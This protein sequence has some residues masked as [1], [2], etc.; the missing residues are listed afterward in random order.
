MHDLAMIQLRD[1]LRDKLNAMTQRFAEQGGRITAL[2]HVEC[3]PYKPLAYNTSI[4]RR[5]HARR[6]FL[7]LEQKIAEHGKALA[8]MGLTPD[9]AARKLRERWRSTPRITSL[10]AEQIAA[11]YGY[12]YADQ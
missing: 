4:T 12:A 3:A 6:E 5:H 10:K 9:Q 11:K 8:A 1:P 2:S 7:E